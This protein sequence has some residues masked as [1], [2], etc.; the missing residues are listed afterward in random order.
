MVRHEK[1]Q[2]GGYGLS[3]WSTFH[4]LWVLM[5]QIFARYEEQRQWIIEE[6]L[7]SLGKSLEQG[8]AQTRYQYVN[9]DLLVLTTKTA[10][11]RFDKHSERSP[12]PAD[13][14]FLPRGRGQDQKTSIAASRS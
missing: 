11:R 7:G 8:S 6:I 1:S 9:C 13:T 12:P 14:S 4:L 3:P 2:N 5:N 10:R